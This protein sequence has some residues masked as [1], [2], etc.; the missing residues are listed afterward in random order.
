MQ[1]T[2]RLGVLASDTEAP[3]VPETAVSANLL[4]PLQIVTELRVDGVR[5]NLAVLAIDNIALPV[6]EPDGDLELRGV[7]DNG[8]EALELVRV[9]LS[10]SVGKVR[11]G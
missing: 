7:L 5:E 8:N 10:G 4:Q 11:L 6:Q 3:E 9:E 2:S 1:L